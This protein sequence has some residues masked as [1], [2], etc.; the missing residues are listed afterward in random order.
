MTNPPT[1][2]KPITVRT[3]L[4]TANSG[5]TSAE[6]AS[7]SEQI[8]VAMQSLDVNPSPGATACQR[9]DIFTRDP[10]TGQVTHT[11]RVLECIGP[12]GDPTSVCT[13][14]VV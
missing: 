4:P 9:E 14:V 7:I 1:P 5:W 6:L 11:V 2:A 12:C 8:T 10:V 3:S 13:W